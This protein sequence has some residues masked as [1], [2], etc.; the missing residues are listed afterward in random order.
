MS[1]KSRKETQNIELTLKNLNSKCM[2]KDIILEETSFQI[3]M[4][5][6]KFI[7]TF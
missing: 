7:S 3:L 6:R 5:K 4:R 1:G 2:F